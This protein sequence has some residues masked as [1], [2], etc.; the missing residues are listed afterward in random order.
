MHNLGWNHI[1]KENRRENSVNTAK[2]FGR[3]QISI[4]QHYAD[5]KFE[6]V[7]QRTFNRTFSFIGSQDAVVVA[8]KCV[9]DKR[10]NSFPRTYTVMIKEDNFPV[11]YAYAVL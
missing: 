10:T 4:W 7:W 3:F 8:T 5:A 2:V 1:L 9:F 6:S 11:L